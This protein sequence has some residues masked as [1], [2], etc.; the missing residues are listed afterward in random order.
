MRREAAPR[1][2]HTRGKGQSQ[3]HDP[4]LSSRLRPCVHGALKRLGQALQ[5]SLSSLSSQ[6]A[7][8]HVNDDSEPLFG[9]WTG[10]AAAF[11]ILPP[12]AN[13]AFCPGSLPSWHFW[14]PYPSPGCRPG[15]RHALAKT[16]HPD[17]VNAFTRAEP[18][19]LHGAPSSVQDTCLQ[20]QPGRNHSSGDPS[21]AA[22]GQEVGDTARGRVGGSVQHS[23]GS[24]KDTIDFQT[25]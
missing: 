24:T 20:N 21:L 1:P 14:T 6:C 12:E 10:E 16:W 2:T 13:T 22:W 25:Y 5:V 4:V 19:E 3:L 17:P 7:P 18:K 11:L 15:Y 8:S 9:V 23:Y